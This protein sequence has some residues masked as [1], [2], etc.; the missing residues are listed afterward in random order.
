MAPGLPPAAASFCS[1]RSMEEA[2]T[3]EWPAETPETEGPGQEA[4]P[5]SSS[6]APEVEE[7]LGLPASMSIEGDE[8]ETVL[9]RSSTLDG[10]GGQS[11]SSWL[12]SSEG[13]ASGS[14]P[15]RDSSWSERSSGDPSSSSAAASPEPPTSPLSWKRRQAELQALEE[16]DD[17]GEESQEP[18]TETESSASAPQTSPGATRKAKEA[19]A[20]RAP[21][22]YTV[23]PV[24]PAEKAELVSVAKAMH[25][26][27]FGKRAKALF[28]LE[29]EAALK[30]LQTGLYIGW[31]CPEYLWDCFRVGDESK[32]FCGHRLKL[33]QVYVE[34]RATVPCTHAE[35]KCQGFMFV[36]SRPEEVGESWLRRRTGFDAAAWRAK[37]RCK[38]THE[39]HTPTGARACCAQGCSCTAFASNFLC[40][41]CDRRWEE[42]ET[43]FES[44]ETRRKGGRPCGEDYLP[45]AEMPDL[46]NTVLTGHPQDNL[47]QRALQGGVPQALPAPS[48]SPAL[49]LPPSGPRRLPEKDDKK[50]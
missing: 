32:C 43:F 38:H 39:E 44:E 50:A 35:C 18:A 19:P 5:S 16:D 17:D 37:C 1:Q 42:H 8:E 12:P 15:P 23:R 34:R 41:A 26:E 48:I 3:E 20:K 4:S 29:K 6:A 25:R 45:F 30:S 33:H 13:E 24:V 9:P 46:R 10:A 14:A 2:E 31:R 49:P 28:H 21:P 11:G 40:A 27:D 7:D 47:T 36:P 22:S